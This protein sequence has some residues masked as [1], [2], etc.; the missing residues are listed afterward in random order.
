MEWVQGTKV[1]H[2]MYGHTVALEKSSSNLI[3]CRQ[4]GVMSQKHFWN[5]SRSTKACT[6]L[7][8]PSPSTTPQMRFMGHRNP[9]SSPSSTSYL[10]PSFF[11]LSQTPCGLICMIMSSNYHIWLLPNPCE[12]AYLSRN[13]MAY[14]VITR[15]CTC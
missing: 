1:A 14:R 5:V 11:V 6:G 7:T 9:S 4:W 13:G 15:V 10:V 12:A 2:S 8:K 3:K